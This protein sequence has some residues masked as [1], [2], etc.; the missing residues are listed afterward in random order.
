MNKALL[1]VKKVV[2]AGNRVVFD[3]EEGSYIE[4]KVTKERMWMREENSMYMLR[5]WVKKGVF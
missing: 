4:D 3:S 2:N 5:L 1:S